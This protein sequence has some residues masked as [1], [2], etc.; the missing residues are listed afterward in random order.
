[1]TQPVE[2]IASSHLHELCSVR[3]DRR[4]GSPGNDV[5]TGYVAADL[6]QSGWQVSEQ[7]FDVLDWSGTPGTARVGR[8]QWAVHPSP[9][10][11]GAETAGPLVVARTRDEVGADL[12]GRVV[13]LLG[14]LAGEPLTPSDYPFYSNEE[15][16]ALVS[17]LVEARPRVVLAGTG[18]APETAGAM[19]PF[20]LIEDGAFPL[21]T[22]N[23]RV[24]DAEAL[25]AHA[26]ERVRVDV[27][28]HRWPSHARNVIARLGNPARRVVLTAH[29]DS[30][31]GTPGALDNAAGV[32]TLLLLARELRGRL[33]DDAL[34]AIG[35]EV[36]VLNGEDCYA[37]PGEQ[38]YLAEYGDT[39]GDVVLAVN[40]DGAG[41]RVGATA[42]SLYGADEP[43][44]RTVRQALDAHPRLVEGP[45][46][47]S[48][49]HMVFAQHGVPA[50][51]LTTDQLQT[52]LNEVVH[53]SHD[54]PAQVDVTLLVDQARALADLVRALLASG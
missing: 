17:A 26:G 6:A 13:L 54:T 2:L 32:V 47:Y 53:T 29:V 42:Y 40:I 45:A 44:A 25:A 14:E 11:R 46:W 24:S 8:E 1:V 35:V 3:P 4:P 50:L 37:A 34:D 38:A 41:Y 23:L 9:Y 49:D 20:P 19:E 18:K 36:A 28:A 51:A 22:A 10:A 16:A 27:T 15:H 21:P 33:A 39:L 5:A 12:S 30:K 52:V 7:T 43:L 31:P 48:S